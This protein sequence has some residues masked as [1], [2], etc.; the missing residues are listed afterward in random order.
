MADTTTS[1]W[2]M[3]VETSCR[4]GSVAIARDGQIV[5]RQNFTADRRHAVELIPAARDLIARQGIAPKDVTSLYVSAGPGS[6]TGMRVGFTFVRALSQVTDAAVFAVPTCR[7]IV[8]NLLPKLGEIS[9]SVDVAVILDAKR[10]QVYA[11]A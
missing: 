10:S 9:E 2:A 1:C 8:E 6:F 11:A 7:V 4:V 3:G 5:D